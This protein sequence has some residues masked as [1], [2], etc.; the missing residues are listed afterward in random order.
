M[1]GAMKHPNQHPLIVLFLTRRLSSA[2][3][4]NA[5]QEGPELFISDNCVHPEEVHPEDIAAVLRR[6][7][8][9]WAQSRNPAT[10]WTPS[11]DARTPQGPQISNP[12]RAGAEPSPQTQTP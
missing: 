9:E 1:S 6:A 11:A 7:G 12:L 10:A 2:A 8:A 3:G 4:M 5:L